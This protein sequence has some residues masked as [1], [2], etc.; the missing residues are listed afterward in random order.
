[1]VT[2]LCESNPISKALR[3]DGLLSTA[4]T[5]NEY[6]KENLSVVEPVEYVLYAR[7]QKNCQ[8]APILMSLSEIFK[9]EMQDFPMNSGKKKKKHRTQKTQKLSTH[10][11]MMAPTLKPISYSLKMIQQ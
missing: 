1:M 7:E 2:E 10:H 6:F 11:F 5:R 4:Y 8:Y 9:R 3:S